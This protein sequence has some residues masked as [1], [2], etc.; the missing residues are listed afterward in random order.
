MTMLNDDMLLRSVRDF[1]ST[2]PIVHKNEP[3]G[4]VVRFV[5]A[6]PSRAV[7]ITDD[8][9]ALAGL[10]T[11]TDLGNL[12]KDPNAYNDPNA[13]TKKAYD[14]A[15]KGLLIAIKDTAKLYQVL[16]IMNGEN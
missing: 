14:L 9:G 10:V 16:K 15:P 12:Y 3:S 4:L 11:P 1:I 8:N 5:T 13:I 7:L 2:A 6:D